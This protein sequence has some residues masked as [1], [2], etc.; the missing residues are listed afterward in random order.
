MPPEYMP[1]PG[2]VWPEEQRPQRPPGNPL[3][4]SPGSNIGDLI[5]RQENACGY[6]GN[7]EE[8]LREIR[9]R[10]FGHPPEKDSQGPI[11]RAIPDGTL[12]ALSSLQSSLHETLESIDSIVN[13]LSDRL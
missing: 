11:G 1:G 2:K 5:V 9:N 12:N 6:A 13:E 4:T 3:A 7:I 8:R 10:L